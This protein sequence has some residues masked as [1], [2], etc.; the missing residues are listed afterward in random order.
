MSFLFD[1]FGFSIIHDHPT[2]GITYNVYIILY[3]ISSFL[4]IQLEVEV[5]F[6]TTSPIGLRY[7]FR[8]SKATSS[9][10]TRR[11]RKNLFQ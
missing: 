3:A 6:Y 8:S 1:L 4:F 10:G 5:L 9:G 2:V 11:Y 7:V